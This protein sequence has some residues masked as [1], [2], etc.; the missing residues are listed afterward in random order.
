MS[1]TPLRSI[2][3]HF[4]IGLQRVVSLQAYYLKV[5]KYSP[6]ALQ[7]A[8]RRFIG[9]SQ[10]HPIEPATPNW[11]HNFW[12]VGFLILVG[13][14]FLEDLIHDRMAEITDRKKRRLTENLDSTTKQAVDANTRA[15]VCRRGS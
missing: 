8:R 7:K 2:S 5:Q 1:L 4:G 15:D 13:G 12:D 14:L 3:G 11:A 10:N 6:D 9:S